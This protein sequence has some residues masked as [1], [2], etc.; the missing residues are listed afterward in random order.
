M[1]RSLSTILAL[2]INMSLL[3]G[4]KSD[5]PVINGYGE[6]W[7]V[8]TDYPTNKIIDYKVIFDIYATPDDKSQI[9]QQLNTIA[10]FLNMHAQAGVPRDQLKVAAVIHNQAST[11]ILMDQYYKERFNVE[12]PNTPL[13]Q[14]LTDQG[15]QLF[16]CGQSSH[17]RDVPKE[18]ILSDIDIA[19]SAMTVLIEFNTQGYTIIKF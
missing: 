17:S 11:D 7:N 14:Q 9:N 3:I 5:G 18:Q 6:V 16:F 1:I 10:R 15:V 2:L 19:L 13:I 4:Q 12:N 8:Q